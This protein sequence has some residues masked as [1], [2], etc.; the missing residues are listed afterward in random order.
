M[1]VLGISI[2]A[3]KVIFS[4]LEKDANST[5]SEIPEAL[6]KLELKN[7]LNANEVREIMA[8]I[9]AFLAHYSFD[10]IG[11]ITRGTKGRFAAS[12]IS[13][14]LEGLIQVFPNV[15][16]DFVAPATLRAFYKKNENPIEPKYSY[17][18]DANN[19]GY[20]LMVN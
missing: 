14:K 12:P 3:N 5:V 17:Q 15:E 11:I 9:H 16:I 18:A 20:Y 19:L 8:E 6:K 1:K 7:H 10:K 4:A 13:F 2:E